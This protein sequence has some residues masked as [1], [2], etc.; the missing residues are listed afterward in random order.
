MFSSVPGPLSP[1]G[2]LLFGKSTPSPTIYI[3]C[4]FKPH[5]LSG[6]FLLLL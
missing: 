4:F 2:E 3:T 1:W 6:D 5:S